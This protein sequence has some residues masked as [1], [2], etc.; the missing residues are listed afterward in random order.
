MA[1]RTQNSPPAG[2]SGDSKTSVRPAVLDTLALPATRSSPPEEKVSQGAKDGS[3][4]LLAQKDTTTRAV[5]TLKYMN[6]RLRLLQNEIAAIIEQF[7][8]GR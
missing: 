8:K 3:A 5:N 2:K 1:K 7:E 6:E 4:I